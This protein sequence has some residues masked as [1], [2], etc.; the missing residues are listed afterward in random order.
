MSGAD[1]NIFTS[2]T[3]DLLAKKSLKMLVENTS[4]LSDHFFLSPAMNISTHGPWQY[5]F[6]LF[7][8]K[9]L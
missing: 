4:G 8:I 2:L 6:D 3:I 9:I 5:C 1:R 7:C